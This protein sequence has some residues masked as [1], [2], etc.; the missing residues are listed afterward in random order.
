M[1]WWCRTAE[2]GKETLQTLQL[3]LWDSSTDTLENIIVQQYLHFKKNTKKENPIE[4]FK[5][6]YEY[7]SALIL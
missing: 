5:P 2:E 3:T 7:K 4:K 6:K 1:I